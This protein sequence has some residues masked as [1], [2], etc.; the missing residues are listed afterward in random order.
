MPELTKNLEIDRYQFAR[1][2]LLE[3]AKHHPIKR[4]YDIGPGDGRMAVIRE[5]GFDWYGFDRQPWRDVR[6][7]D[8]S[9]AFPYEE[10]K[11]DTV[12]LLEVIEHSPNPGLALRNISDQIRA[13]GYLILTTPNPYWSGSRL[14][15]FFRGII[16]G[17]SPQDLAENFHVFTPWSHVL[18]RFMIDVGL[19]IE[20]YV[21]LEGR[22]KLFS[23]PGKLFVVARYFLNAV[24]IAFESLDSR[25]QGMTMAFVA[26]KLKTTAVPAAYPSIAGS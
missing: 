8:I 15:Y 5:D 21:T 25:S 1:T 17:F 6:K 2:T 23:R 26:R 11:A 12:L 16:S 4:V 18:E 19:Q 7:W 24:N 3:L 14:N 13:G 20:Q 10:P 9:E 22:T